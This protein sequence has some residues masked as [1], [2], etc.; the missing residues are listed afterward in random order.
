M[1]TLPVLLSATMAFLATVSAGIFIKK[2]K[3]NIGIVCAFSSGFFVALSVFDLLPTVLALASEVQVPLDRLSLTAIVGFVFLFAINRGFSRF[4]MNNHH[5]AER[6]VEPKIGVLATLE[7]C[8]H[9]FLEGIAIGVSFQLEFGLGVFVALAVV[10]HDFCDGI[11]T[12]ALML[13]SGN[14]LKS[15]ISMLFVGALAPVLGASVT[16][17]FAIQ[18]YFLVYALAFL[19][20]S[21]LY[22]GAGTLLPD[23]YRMNR[24]IV[25][26]IFFLVGFL[27]ILSFTQIIT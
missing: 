24:P 14:T 16:L 4:H 27:L 13:N 3:S 18:S 8:S 17:F 6:A 1:N 21:F 23:A 5:A 9:A 2:F 10:S 7:F 25:T 22:I 26:V 12:L 20:G 11:S 19:F 15:S